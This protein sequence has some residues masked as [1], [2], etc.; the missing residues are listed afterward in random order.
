MNRTEL[1]VKRIYESL[2]IDDPH[3]LSIE[4]LSSKMNI[5][6]NYWEFTSEITEFEGIYKIFINENL[7]VQQQWQ[8]FGHE[9]GHYLQHDGTQTNM[10]KLF[11]NHQESQAEY[12]S[13]HFCVPTFMLMKLIGA[14]IYDVMNLFNVEFDFALK[15]LEMYQNKIIM[16]GE[17]KWQKDMQGTV[18]ETSGSWK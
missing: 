18:V 7:N 8:D 6:V 5:C 17:S 11:L 4:N 1:Y 9:L 10:Y 16:K 12:F 13:Y 3:E 2:S 15:R 14:T